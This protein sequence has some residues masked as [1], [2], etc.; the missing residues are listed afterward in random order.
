M[1]IP[2]RLKHGGQKRRDIIASVG[3]EGFDQIVGKMPLCEILITVAEQCTQRLSG[4][5]QQFGMFANP[6]IVVAD[7]GLGIKGIDRVVFFGDG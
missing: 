6:V 2:R 5:S 4:V 1:L 3:A 7:N